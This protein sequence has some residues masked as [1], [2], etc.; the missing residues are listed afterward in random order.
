MAR[1]KALVAER[2]GWR[3]PLAQV[4]RMRQWV[5]DAEHILDGSWCRLTHKFA[6]TFFREKIVGPASHQGRSLLL[7]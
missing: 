6:K 3:E 1:L 2:A 5:L 7:F 4:K